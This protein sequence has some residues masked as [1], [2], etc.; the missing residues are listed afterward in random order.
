MRLDYM[1][2]LVEVVPQTFG[3]AV[4]LYPWLENECESHEWDNR[5]TIQ[6]TVWLIMTFSSKVKT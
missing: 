6:N 1:D 5:T 2:E 3:E 4:Q